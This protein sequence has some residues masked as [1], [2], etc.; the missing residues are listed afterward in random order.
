MLF[1]HRVREAFQSKKLG[2]FG[3]GPNRQGGRVVKRTQKHKVLSI[4]VLNMAKFTSISLL[5]IDF[6]P[7]FFIFNL[8]LRIFRGSFH[9]LKNTEQLL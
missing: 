4:V 6:V 8:F 5:L 2:N 7:I 3:L 9:F 1:F